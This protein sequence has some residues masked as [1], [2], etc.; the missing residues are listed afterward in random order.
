MVTNDWYA[1]SIQAIFKE[2]GTNERGLTAAVAALRARQFGP[3]ELPK[4]KPEGL[5]VIFLRQ[6]QSPLIYI[7]LAA[8]GVVFLLGETADSIIIFFI[9]FFNAI[10]G[11]VQEGRAQNTLRALATFART[12]ATVVRDGTELIIPDRDVVPGDVPI[13]KEG[14]K[15]PADARILDTR[16]LKVDESSLT[17]ES[18]PVGKTTESIHREHAPTA[19]QKNMVFKGT[20]IVAGN[21]RA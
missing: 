14:E 1:K 8:G 15:M 16:A 18:S 5:L 21:G 12:V 11:T 17:G 7:L 20:H 3:N 13:L 19:E 9:L 10:V 2:L 6:F 4:A